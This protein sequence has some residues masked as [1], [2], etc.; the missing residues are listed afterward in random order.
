MSFPDRLAVLID[1]EWLCKTL[2]KQN[3]DRQ[4]AEAQDTSDVVREV[5]ETP[6]LCDLLL[7]RAFYY[8]AAPPHR[9]D[10]ESVEWQ[11]A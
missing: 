7:Y 10:S 4:P 2:R 5:S 3:G 9:R 8:T 11:T 6:G 1:G